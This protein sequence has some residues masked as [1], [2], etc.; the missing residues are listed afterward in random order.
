[1]LHADP[2]AAPVLTASFGRDVTLAGVVVRPPQRGSE[3]V[4]A[5]VSVEHI[6]PAGRSSPA[7][8]LA[9]VTFPQ[10][11]DVLY[12]DRIAISGRP[13]RPPPAGNPGASSSR[14]HLAPRG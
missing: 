1:M 3:H 6:D 4:R 10:S 11:S 5:V 12:G 2:A 14:Y 7:D 13:V 9:L 8:G